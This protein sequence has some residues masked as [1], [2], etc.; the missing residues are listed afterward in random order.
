MRRRKPLYLLAA[1]VF[2]T[3]SVAGIAISTASPDTTDLTE[4]AVSATYVSAQSRTTNFDN[5][6]VLNASRISY[7]AL[8]QFDTTL[9]DGATFDSATLT[10]NSGTSNGGM[11]SVY[12]VASFDPTT[13]TWSN[14]PALQ[15]DPLGTSTGPTAM[16][17]QVIPLTGLTIGGVANL[18]IT[19]SVPQTVARL[20][21]LTNSPPV[22]DITYTPAA[23]VTTDPSSTTT[24]SAPDS[25]TTTAATTPPSSTSTTSTPTS[26]DPS[27]T[28]VP[29]TTTTAPQGGTGHKMLVI[30]EENHSEDESLS[31]MPTL[32][33]YA[34]QFGQAT[35]Y[36]GIGH[37]SLPNYVAIFSGD[38]QGI[39]SDC[40][41]GPSCQ[42]AG[43]TV[44]SQ[45]IDAGETAKAYQESMATNCQASSS[46]GYVARHG[47]W[48]YFTDS[49]DAAECAADDVPLGTTTA[50]NLLDDVNSGNLPVTGE[51]TPNLNDDAHDGTPA[52]ADAWLGQWL[53]VIMAGPDYT[54]G[55]LTIV[56]TF[57]ED[58]S[59]QGND[60]Q[61]VAIDPRLSHVVVTAAFNHYSLTRWLDDNAGVPLLRNAATAPDLRSAF[62]L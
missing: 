36:T 37:P 35:D 11:F 51:I 34:D 53:P 38:S 7:R 30:M 12:S 22:L 27:T 25:T 44:W 17:S 42:P 20:S 49:T 55:N 24:T 16:G 2:L 57:D 47:P 39:T 48:P 9:P 40:D 23:P 32:T 19:Y 14:R 28:T 60:I 29:S 50:G 10:I 61:F 46:G 1:G 21:G 3:A 4:T 33:S 45:T 31:Q 6:P 8:L 43:P 13:V 52:Q 58:D 18:A 62:G 59:T 15:G 56:I 41:V 54:S 26:T 5:S